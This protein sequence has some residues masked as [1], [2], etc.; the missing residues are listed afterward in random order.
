MQ[1]TIALS[2]TE[3]EC[4]ASIEVVKEAFL[5]QGLLNDLVV[6]QEVLS[7]FCDSMSDIRLGKNQVSHARTKHI[8]VYYHFV[9]EILEKGDLMVKV[10]E[11]ID[12]STIMLTKIVSEIKLQHCKNLIHI[13]S[14]SWH[15]LGDGVHGGT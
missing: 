9:C 7:V 6:G 12:N 1:P 3:A 15:P 5:L 8:D 10:V 2:T 11:T 14:T 13:P 4:M